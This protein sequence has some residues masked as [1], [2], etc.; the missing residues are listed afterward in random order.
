MLMVKEAY[1]PQ[2]QLPK[3]SLLMKA[4]GQY[5]N[6]LNDNSDLADYEINEGVYSN[7]NP[8]KTMIGLN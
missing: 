3:H 2:S 6:G 7:L 5:R 4:P 1:M 8:A